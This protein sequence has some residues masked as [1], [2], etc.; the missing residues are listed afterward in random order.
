MI[1]SILIAAYNVEPFIEKCIRSC[2]DAKNKEH[3]EII[4]INDGSTD[5]TAIKLSKLLNEVGN[6]KVINKDNEGLGA[7]RN[8]G[9]ENAK[10]EYIWMIDGDDFIE[11]NQIDFFLKEI[12]KT[13][14][15]LYCMN[16]NI[17]DKNGIVSSIAHPEEKAEEVHNA[18][19]Y[20]QHFKEHSYTWQ[21]IFQKSIFTKNDLF[22][23]SSINMQDSE[24]FPKIIYYSNEIKYLP[25]VGYNYVQHP[26][27]FT[28]AIDFKKRLRYFESIV[29][30]DESLEKFK[31]SIV[32]S[33]PS[34]AE[35]IEQ[36][37]KSLH[38]I[39]FNHLI[40]FKYS[41]DNFKYTLSYLKKNNYY[42]LQYMPTGKL[43]MI[44]FGMNYVP[45]LT[46]KVI[47]CIRK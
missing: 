7:A 17:T 15:H 47:D 11:T 21:Y 26:N 41:S 18:S 19:D 45:L 23:K 9:I 25:V 30:V 29:A 34:L 35:A 44:K 24:I 27:S 4:V 36:K 10:G 38:H 6:L 8:I 43:K 20:Y 42:P 33:N 32:N 14:F 22:F 5:R 28:N 1:L 37:Q 46:K 3:Y 13:N 2:F 40:F 39:I 16:Y 12:G 31:K